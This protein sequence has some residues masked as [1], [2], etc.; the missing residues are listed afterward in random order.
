ML[1]VLEDV[2]GICWRLLVLTDSTV[3]QS[4]MLLSIT[5]EEEEEVVEE[6]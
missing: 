3:E 5:R 6:D 4:P 2:N 1:V